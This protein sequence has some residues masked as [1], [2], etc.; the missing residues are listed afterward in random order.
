ATDDE[1]LRQIAIEHCRTTQRHLVRPD[2][3]TAHEGLFDVTTGRF[4]RESTHQGYAPES[5]WTRGLAWALYGFTAVHR[6]L[7]PGPPRNAS[8]GL[9]LG[10][11]F[12]DTARRCA[13]CYLR[14]CQAARVPPAEFDSTNDQPQHWYS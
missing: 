6:L 14:R 11:E 8:R 2:G 9:G 1:T 12:L 5:T 3:G 4:L 13:V 7:G 10:D